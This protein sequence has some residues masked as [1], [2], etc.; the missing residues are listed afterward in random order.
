MADHTH[1]TMNTNAQEKTFDGFVKF[2][3]RAVVVIIVGLALLAMI[4]G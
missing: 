3:S 4:N 2:V 1:G